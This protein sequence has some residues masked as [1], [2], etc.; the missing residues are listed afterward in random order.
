MCNVDE[1]DELSSFSEQRKLLFSFFI[2][3]RRS[4]DFVNANDIKYISS[5]AT[6]MRNSPSNLNI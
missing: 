3:A 4:P 5:S 1:S 2:Q 6:S